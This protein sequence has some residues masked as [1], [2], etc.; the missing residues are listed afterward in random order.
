VT[1][2]ETISTVVGCGAS[3]ACDAAAFVRSS[4]AEHGE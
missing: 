4:S 1:A 3:F 2:L